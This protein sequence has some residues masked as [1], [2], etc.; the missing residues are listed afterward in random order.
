MTDD[1]Q[2]AVGNYGDLVTMNPRLYCVDCERFVYITSP[3][4]S[5]P[6]HYFLECECSIASP[7][8]RLDNW[9]SVT[10]LVS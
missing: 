3:E 9:N 10:E 5:T 2:G 7:D 1:I 8:D 4:E 6:T